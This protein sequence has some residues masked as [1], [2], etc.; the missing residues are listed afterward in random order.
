MSGFGAEEDMQLS[1]AA[2]FFDHLIK[3]ID[4]TRLDAAI[5]RATSRPV[6]FDEPSGP[7]NAGLEMNGSRC[8]GT[9]RSGFQPDILSGS[10]GLRTSVPFLNAPK[11]NGSG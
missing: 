11:P 7:F 2:G 3:P 9:G 1:R 6:E 8:R 5:H 4:P 10:R